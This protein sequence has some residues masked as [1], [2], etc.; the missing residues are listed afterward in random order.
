MA[1]RILALARDNEPVINRAFAAHFRA[2][3]RAG[4]R[5]DTPANDSYL[6]DHG[7]KEYVVLCNSR[8]VM[9]V[10]RVRNDGILKGLKRWP[11]D[12]EEV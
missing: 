2:A 5:A 12:I 8:G 10:Y 9:A 6:I 4:G 11:K 3:S 1:T 7:G